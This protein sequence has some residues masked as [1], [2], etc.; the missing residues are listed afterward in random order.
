MKALSEQHRQSTMREGAGDRQ[1]V[2][3]GSSAVVFSARRDP[4]KGAMA[5]GSRAGAA[6][7]SGEFQNNYA[8]VPMAM[9]P[10]HDRCRVNP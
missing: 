3:G 2:S 5:L 6:I 1:M 7:S 9:L 4:G 8:I 10:R